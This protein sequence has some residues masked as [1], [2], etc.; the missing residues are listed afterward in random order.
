MHIFSFVIDI[1]LRPL[2]LALGAGMHP[3]N[4]NRHE[5]LSQRLE[6]AK[7]II[8]KGDER[9]KFGARNKQGKF[10]YGPISI[11]RIHIF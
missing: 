10:Y 3:L 11:L 6:I 4:R 2:L 8:S 7:Y 9:N 1:F 5:N